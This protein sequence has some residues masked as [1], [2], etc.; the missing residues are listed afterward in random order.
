MSP[1]NAITE[2]MD[3]GPYLR[4]PA[5]DASTPEGTDGS[6]L[7]PDVIAFCGRTLHRQ[8]MIG[9]GG[10]AK[11]WLYTTREKPVLCAAVKCSKVPDESV[12]RHQLHV[13]QRIQRVCGGVRGVIGHLDLVGGNDAEDTLIHDNMLALP[14][15]N[16]VPLSGVLAYGKL[17]EGTA[18]QVGLRLS[19][20]MKRLHNHNIIHA[21]IKPDNIMLAVPPGQASVRDVCIE[22][23]DFAHAAIQFDPEHPHIPGGTPLYMSPEQWD[24][25]LKRTTTIGSPTDV[26][27]T[28]H[29]LFHMTTGTTFIPH[30]DGDTV[31]GLREKHL[32]CIDGE[33]DERIDL[34]PAV[35]RP[36]FVD[37]FR[38]AEK[39]PTMQEVSRR[40]RK[41]CELIGINPNGPILQQPIRVTDGKISAAQMADWLRSQ[42]NLSD[43]VVQ[44]ST[45][46]T[47]RNPGA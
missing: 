40:L 31:L 41:V 11:V 42:A 29:T 3:M 38:S 7:P 16:G 14:F 4:T 9:S 2:M 22:V 43:T 44:R 23:I 35:F 10:E 15:I 1:N 18:A 19:N 33:Y 30:E 20:R 26:Y 27:A 37:I 34:L 28:G 47:V 39:R 36:V 46:P 21:D 5:Q 24:S 12:L 25:F 6:Q 13:A 45:E 32:E 17:E 8:R